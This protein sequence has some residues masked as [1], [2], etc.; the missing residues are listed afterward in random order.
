MRLFLSLTLTVS[1]LAGCGGGGPAPNREPVY[2]I[3]GVVTYKGKAVASADVTFVCTEKD[4][5]AF[6]RTD[7]EGRF[8]LSTFSSNDG[9]VAGKHVIMVTKVEPQ[10]P[11]TP[12]ADISTNDYQPPKLGASTDPVKPKNQI[13]AKYADAKSSDVFVVVNADGANDEVKV[14]LKD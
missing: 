1:V 14:E 2:P 11:T 10:A 12:V 5:S 13:P 6:G 7:A 3:S 4:R 8:K 9:A